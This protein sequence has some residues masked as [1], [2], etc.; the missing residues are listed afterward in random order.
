MKS[1]WRVLLDSGAPSTNA[2]LTQ[3]RF[4]LDSGSASSVLIDLDMSLATADLPVDPDALRAFALACQSELK[5]AETAVQLKAAAPLA[6]RS[7][8]P[9]RRSPCPLYN[10]CHA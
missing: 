8:G 9:G 7:S 2:A 5:A 3:H 1:I 6:G 10:R 4:V